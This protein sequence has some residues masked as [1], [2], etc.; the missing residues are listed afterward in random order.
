MK[1]IHNFSLKS[2][3]TF[4]IECTAAAFVEYDSADE[5]MTIGDMIRKGELPLPVVPI[6]GGSNILFGKD[7]FEGTILHSGIKTVEQLPGCEGCVRVKV[8]S[9]YVW[10]DFVK[11]CV[12]NGWYGAENLSLIPGETGG[13]AVQN[14]GAYG[15]EVKD[16]IEEVECF[17]LSSGKIKTFKKEECRYGYRDSI[18]KSPEYR[19]FVVTNVIFSL[20]LIPRFNLSYS[21]LSERFANKKSLTMN[22]LRECIMTTRRLKLPDPENIGSAGSFFKNPVVFR[23]KFE[24]IR[25]EFPDVPYYDVLEMPD[26][27]KLC[28]GWLIEKCNW[29]GRALGRAGVYE[30]QALVLVNRGGATGEDIIALACAVIDSVKKRFNV[31][32]QKEVCII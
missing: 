16:I 7:R 1:I 10:D 9:G 17:D 25:E 12:G 11:L 23:K 20:S 18:F 21:F 24:K 22:D 4:G 27:V 2:Y 31:E 19:S 3:N 13:A 32:L 8:G 6:G 15:A 28:A 5:L 14:I 30:K 26:K 29:K